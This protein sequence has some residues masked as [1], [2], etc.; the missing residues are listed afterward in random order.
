M[1]QDYAEAFRLFRQAVDLGYAT[2]IY[3]LGVCYFM[4]QGVKQD[5]YKGVQLLRQAA[6]LGITLPPEISEILEFLETFS[7]VDMNQIIRSM[8]GKISFN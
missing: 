4:G 1:K 5:I 6:D 7:Q 8:G 2:A 3:Y